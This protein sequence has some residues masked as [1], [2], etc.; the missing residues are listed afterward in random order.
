[1]KK[2]AL[3][4]LFL[5]L[6]LT[7]AG[8]IMVFSASTVSATSAK[9]LSMYHYFYRQIMYALVGLSL[10]GIAVAFDYRQFRSPW[11]YIPLAAV[12]IGL[13]IAV[14]IPGVGV[15]RNSARRW[16]MLGPVQFQPSELGKFALVILLSVVL[17][18]NEANLKKFFRGFMPPMILTV[19]MAGLVAAEPDFGI[20]AVMCAVGVIMVFSAGARLSH[21]FISAIPLGIG[22]AALIVTSPE[23]VER[24]LIFMDP[25]KDPLGGGFN[26]IQSMTGFA[27]GGLVGVGAGAGE[28]KLG[29]LYGAHTDFIFAVF[30]EEL[31]F[32]GA[33]VVVTSFL[34]I[35]FLGMRVA[36]NAPDQFGSLLATGIV[37][38]FTIQ[39]TINMSV[40][41]GL[42]PTKGLTLP[43]V[44]AGGASLIVNLAMAG[45]LLNIALQ[46]REE[47]PVR[48]S[49]RRT[50]AA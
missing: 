21:L 34:C 27:R 36:A 39:A 38:L 23:R 10:M 20:P 4:I 6:L 45:V 14:L 41:I 31:G 40:A 50:A 19:F 47:K 44:S 2:E 18:A 17:C 29:Y 30:G 1:M 33:A 26:L 28:Q 3:G 15:V 8:I 24:L 43:F 42:V 25:W 46:A 32:I 5:I 9:G 13:L 49:R 48:G 22:A 7:T 35:F 12:A 11:L 16:M 37:T